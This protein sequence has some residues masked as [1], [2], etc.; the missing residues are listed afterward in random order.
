MSHCG[1]VD[2]DNTSYPVL[3]YDSTCL[4]DCESSDCCINALDEAHAPRWVYHENCNT[5]SWLMT[6]TI[7]TRDECSKQCESNPFCTGMAYNE[8]DCSLYAAMIC[9][10]SLLTCGSCNYSSKGLLPW[11]ETT[12]GPCTTD[13]SVGVYEGISAAACERFCDDDPKC[14]G[15]VIS[16]MDISNPLVPVGSQL[17]ISCQ[18][19]GKSFVCNTT[20]ETSSMCDLDTQSCYFQKISFAD[21]CQAT[22]SEYLLHWGPILCITT[23]TGICLFA[24]ALL[25][26]TFRPGGGGSEVYLIPCILLLVCAGP[27]FC[28]FIIGTDPVA[29]TSML[30]DCPSHLEPPWGPFLKY[31]ES[32]PPEVGFEGSLDF[33]S[34]VENETLPEIDDWTSLSKC[35]QSVMWPPSLRDMQLPGQPVAMGDY[36]IRIECTDEGAIFT[37]HRSKDGTCETPVWNLLVEES[38]CNSEMD[39]PLQVSCSSCDWL[40]WRSVKTAPYIV[41]VVNSLCSMISSFICAYVAMKI[42]AARQMLSGE[43]TDSQK[44]ESN[45]EHCDDTLSQKSSILEIKSSGSDNMEVASSCT[46]FD[47]NG[48]AAHS[49]H[50]V[51]KQKNNAPDNTSQTGG[52]KD[53]NDSNKEAPIGFFMIR[54]NRIKT[55]ISEL[56]DSL[57]DE[58]LEED[59]L[60]DYAYRSASPSFYFILVKTVYLA[61]FFIVSV[62]LADEQGVSGWQTYQLIYT[63]FMNSGIVLLLLESVRAVF[64]SMKM[65]EA[66]SAEDDDNE[67]PDVEPDE[68][69]TARYCVALTFI[70]CLFFL[71]AF[72]TH[73]VP[74]AAMFPWMVVLLLFLGKLFLTWPIKIFDKHLGK[75]WPLLVVQRPLR[76]YLVTQLLC[77]WLKFVSSLVIVLPI[78][79]LWNYG[80]LAYQGHPY[81]MIPQ[82][83]FKSRNIWCFYHRPWSDMA[84]GMQFLSFYF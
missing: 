76:A 23:L 24:F 51:D 22:L 79:M 73:V 20:N 5:S 14:G 62:V 44:S 40:W 39:V 84:T 68:I 13:F 45:A 29:R 59:S 67:Q 41:M 15:I 78:Q 19:W 53:N 12:A 58:M 80:V 61:V 43:Q 64:G 11:Y 2:C 4:S 77:V 65:I 25:C 82:E 30:L 57:S 48:E 9:S 35:M 37:Q 1:L 31:N 36:D 55:Y 32:D 52:E 69:K 42:K 17:N 27:L 38:V 72:V 34:C 10:A 60:K 71:P 26:S 63:R 8:S 16:Q 49:N 50:T 56:A 54:I 21:L 81:W 46:S 7:T 74:M 70:T 33:K 28:L 6:V 66:A 3:S 47:N 83:E 75:N 18:L